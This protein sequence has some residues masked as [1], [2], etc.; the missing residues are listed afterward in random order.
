MTISPVRLVAAEL[1]KISQ[2]SFY[3]ALS[4]KPLCVS[5]P[6][7]LCLSER[8]FY[9]A[10]QKKNENPIFCTLPKNRILFFMPDCA[11]IHDSLFRLKNIRSLILSKC[12]E[13]LPIRIVRQDRSRDRIAI[14]PI[15]YAVSIGIVPQMCFVA[16]R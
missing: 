2:I 3:Y 13:E 7:D 12:P 11:V 16:I 4:P 9:G 10:W 14:I 8:R 5:I 1:F 15:E 6:L